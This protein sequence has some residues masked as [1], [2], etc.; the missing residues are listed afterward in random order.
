MRW[1]QGI[2]SVLFAAVAQTVVAAPAAA[3]T[4]SSYLNKRYIEERDGVS[5]NVF[6]HH[7]TGSKM[8]FIKNSGVCETTPGVNQYSGY[9]EVGRNMSMWFW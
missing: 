3:T 7:E 5:Y 9:L 6:E 8:S 4:S 2:A 1:A